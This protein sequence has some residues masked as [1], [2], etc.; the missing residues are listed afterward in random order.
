MLDIGVLHVACLACEEVSEGTG[1]TSLS[2]KLE[3]TGCVDLVL[4]EL[5]NSS[6]P[7]SFLEEFT[8]GGSGKF[9]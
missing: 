9:K 6:V 3:V 8:A 7:M 2:L 5:L 4:N 1:E